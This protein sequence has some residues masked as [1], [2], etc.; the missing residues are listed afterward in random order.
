VA[1]NSPFVMPMMG[2]GI[3]AGNGTSITAIAVTKL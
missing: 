1:R 2:A 3:A